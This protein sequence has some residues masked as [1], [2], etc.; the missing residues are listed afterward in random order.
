MVV[1]KITK[2][3]RIQRI[4]EEITAGRSEIGKPYAE[5][6]PWQQELLDMNVESK[7]VK[8]RTND[9]CF[10]TDFVLKS[11]TKTLEII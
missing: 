8:V 10:G 7:I 2:D 9:S 1:S 3:Q 5:M 6:K 4:N 11:F